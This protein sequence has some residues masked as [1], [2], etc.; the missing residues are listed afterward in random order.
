M[1]Q[2]HVFESFVYG[3]CVKNILVKTLSLNTMLP[4]KEPTEDVTAESRSQY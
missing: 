1:K 3:L 4:P 2:D